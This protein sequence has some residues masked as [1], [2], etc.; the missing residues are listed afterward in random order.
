[1]DE[2]TRRLAE[3][4]RLREAKELAESL[5][6]VVTCPACKREKSLP[7]FILTGEAIRAVTST[8]CICGQE[9]HFEPGA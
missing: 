9:I 6:I 2:E 3:K 8:T 5:R 1:M 4:T 7:A